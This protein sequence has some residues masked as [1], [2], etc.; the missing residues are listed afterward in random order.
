[1]W[2]T[3]FSAS[4]IPFFQPPA[5]AAPAPAA[6]AAAGPR[7]KV[8]LLGASGGIGQPLGLLLKL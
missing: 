5:A 8:A 6:A 3:C 7:F 2:L 1:V 4:P